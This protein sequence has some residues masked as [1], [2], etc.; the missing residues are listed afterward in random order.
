MKISLTV[1]VFATALAAA[2]F[3]SAAAAPVV[4]ACSPPLVGQPWR[5]GERHAFWRGGEGDHD[6]WRHRHRDEFLGPIGPIV[7]D[8]S[9]PGTEAT[10]SPFVVSAPVFV[11]V[12][13]A[14]AAEPPRGWTDGPKLIVIGRGA[15]QHGHLP[16][17]IYGD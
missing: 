4:R 8:A 9:E 5:G 7:G 6:F 15:P 1:S 3:A 16:L 11:N 10:P 17:I 2:P 14:P 12:T 13:L